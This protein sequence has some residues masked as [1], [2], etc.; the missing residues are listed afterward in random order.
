M[1]PAHRAGDVTAELRGHYGVP[2]L[3]KSL[4][5][6]GN[7]ENDDFGAGARAYWFATDSLALGGGASGLVFKTLGDD[8]YAAEGESAL[9]WYPV[10]FDSCSLFLDGTVGFQQST[11]RVPDDGTEWNFTFSFGPGCEIPLGGGTS[12]LLGGMYHH[13]S[14]ALGRRNSRNPS[15]NEARLWVGVGWFF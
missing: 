11:R 1:S 3:R 8:A 7:G 9:R 5:W 12:V 10:S 6:D 15:Q 14:N 2:I 4:F 13:I